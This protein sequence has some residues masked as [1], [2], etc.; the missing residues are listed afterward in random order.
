MNWERT[1][2]NNVFKE[3]T[4]NL[5]LKKRWPVKTETRS[6]QMGLFDLIHF[7]EKRKQIQH[8]WLR[9]V[10]MYLE[11]SVEWGNSKLKDEDSAK[12]NELGEK[13][14]SEQFCISREIETN[15]YGETYP[16]DTKKSAGKFVAKKRSIPEEIR[17]KEIN[18]CEEDGCRIKLIRLTKLKELSSK[19]KICLE[20]QPVVK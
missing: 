9:W 3:T 8:E 6:I 20:M 2:V 11:W 7:I 19:G 4:Y 13:I 17:M 16:C 14:S 15:T 12:L 1:E 5:T 10:G 18:S